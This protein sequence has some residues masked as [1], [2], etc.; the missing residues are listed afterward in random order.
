MSTFGSPPRVALPGSRRILKGDVARCHDLAVSSSFLSGRCHRH[1]I[2]PFSLSGP[3]FLM[4][5]PR[6]SAAR[7]T[8]PQEIP[9]SLAASL[10]SFEPTGPPLSSAARKFLALSRAPGDLFSDAARSASVAVMSTGSGCHT[11]CGA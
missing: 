11:M 6:S 8:V 5:T 1:V 7:R 10:T 3:S 4:S 2:S 9:F